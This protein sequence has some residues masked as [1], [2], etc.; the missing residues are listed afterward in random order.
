MFLDKTYIPPKTVTLPRDTKDD[1]HTNKNAEYPTSPDAKYCAQVLGPILAA[2][3]A[4]IAEVRPKDPI[5]YLAQYLYKQD[6]DSHRKA[7]VG[8][9]M[10]LSLVTNK[11]G[12]CKRKFSMSAKVALLQPINY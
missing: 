12:N 6:M 8:A 9:T 7:E 2:A 5:E 11:L 1:P 10:W 3:M 4:E